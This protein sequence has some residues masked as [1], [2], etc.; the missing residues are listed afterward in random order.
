VP[1]VM[2]FRRTLSKTEPVQ[3]KEATTL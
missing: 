2:L 1:V 3:R